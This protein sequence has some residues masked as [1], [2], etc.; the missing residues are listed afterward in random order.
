LGGEAERSLGWTGNVN[1]S[2]RNRLG[3]GF[4]DPGE[5]SDEGENDG[6]AEQE[7]DDETDRDT[8]AAV[9]AVAPG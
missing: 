1:R 6:T 4:S 3:D 8:E 5:E 2:S 9:P 7:P